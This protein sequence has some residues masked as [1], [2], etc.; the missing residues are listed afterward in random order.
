MKTR[1][2]KFLVDHGFFPSREKARDAILQQTVTVN[3]LVIDKPSYMVGE[4]EKVDIIDI[5]NRYVS[6][7]GLKLE[8]A[9]RTFDLDFQGK[10]VLDVG[11]STGGF[12]DCALQHGADECVCVDVG[13]DQLHSSLKDHHYVIS[14]ENMDFR[15]LKP[16]DIG[17]RKFDFIVS[18][19]SF[20][21]LS[22]LLPYFPIYLKPEGHMVLLIKPQ[23]EAGASFLN[24]NGIVTDEKAYKLSIQKVVK[25]AL[26]HGFYLN[27]ITIS[28]LYEL[29]K[30]VEF[31]GLFSLKS[32]NFNL[33]F[34]AMMT[35]L[36]SIRKN[37]KK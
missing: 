7:G 8:K 18:D 32:N 12:T 17:N 29:K 34:N 28:T 1:L 2:D 23:F 27:G 20:I 6:R 3:Q 5:F 31:L 14:I 21:S 13:Q 11:A 30:N 25:E 26:S 36:K 19:V 10:T 22:Y 37:L 33:D 15:E 24:K 4:N 9:I 35:E 16:E